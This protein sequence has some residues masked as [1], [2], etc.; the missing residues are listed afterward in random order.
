VPHDKKN[1][2]PRAGVRVDAFAEVD[3]DNSRSAAQ[4]QVVATR[5]TI[6][7]ASALL[8]RVE[9]LVRDLPGEYRAPIMGSIQRCQEVLGAA[10][11][12]EAVS[13][14]LGAGVRR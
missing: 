9:R 10:L 7:A 3:P 1:A 13:R 14:A 2:G 11:V 5:A 12:G 6:R 4:P 8:S